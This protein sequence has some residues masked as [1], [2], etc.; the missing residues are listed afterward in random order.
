M[1]RKKT[2]LLTDAEHRIMEVLWAK[3][4]ATVAEVAESR[5]IARTCFTSGESKWIRTKATTEGKLLTRSFGDCVARL[6]TS[7]EIAT[8]W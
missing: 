6:P 7:S 8:P 5:G 1:P 4:S 3:G 2:V